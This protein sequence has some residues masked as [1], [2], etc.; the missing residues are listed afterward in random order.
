MLKIK[1]T[2]IGSRGQRNVWVVADSIYSDEVPNTESNRLHSCLAGMPVVLA[3]ADQTA[4]Y[5]WIYKPD[6]DVA[7]DLKIGETAIESSDHASARRLHELKRRAIDTGMTHMEEL[8]LPTHGSR[9]T[10][11][12]AASPV[13]EDNTPVGVSMIA[14]DVTSLRAASEARAQLREEQLRLIAH[15]LRQPLNVLAIAAGRLADA[16]EVGSPVGMISDGITASVR[17]M[18]RLLADILDSD[19]WE[20]TGVWLRYEPTDVLAFL[21]DTFNT[22][23]T[24]DGLLRVR[25]VVDGP[26]QADLDRA[27]FGR[28]VL[29]LV[30]NALK[31]SPIAEPVRI[32]VSVRSDMLRVAVSD[33]GPGLDQDTAAHA[34]DKYQAS[35]GSRASGGKGL[36]LY[37]ARLIVEAHGGSCRVESEP[38][39]GATFS[40]ELP[41]RPRR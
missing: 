12:T 20:K 34:F 1:C 11:V 36:G 30:D 10:F 4:R 5:V 21:R 15:D 22:G 29:N 39:H 41:C 7:L 18:N 37:C 32:H 9:R 40:I 6:P 31:F 28:A 16:V 33:G 13:L 24:P 17:A 14:F 2:C 25:L 19:E 35:V 38:G 26:C 27:K 23:I 3:I 8:E